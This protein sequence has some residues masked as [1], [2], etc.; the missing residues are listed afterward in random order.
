MNRGPL[1]RVSATIGVP[2]ANPNPVSHMGALTG[3]WDVY[4]DRSLRFRINALRDDRGGNVWT[5]PAG[6]A[7]TNWHAS[8]NGLSIGS[9]GATL[10][11]AELMLWDQKLTAQDRDALTAYL[12]NKWGLS[13]PFVGV[14][15][16]TVSRRIRRHTS[17]NT[18]DRA[19]RRASP[20]SVVQS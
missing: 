20:G 4:S 12:T 5:A 14:S 15:T 1:S 17:F 13:I 9:P 2:T 18:D 16:Q 6:S 11:L 3:S 7:H 10:R 19:Q 8:T